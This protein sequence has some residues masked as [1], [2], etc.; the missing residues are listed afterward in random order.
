MIDELLMAGIKGG[1]QGLAQ[2]LGEASAL[3]H[4]NKPMVG[5]LRMQA[6]PR[7]GVWFALAAFCVYR[8]KNLITGE[9]RDIAF[10]EMTL[11]TATQAGG[12][13]IALAAGALCAWAGWRTYRVERRVPS[14]GT[15][16][17]PGYRLP[18]FGEWLLAIVGGL[19]LLAAIY[20]YTTIPESLAAGND[21]RF[22]N[23]HSASAMPV[24]VWGT[25][26]GVGGLLCLIVRRSRWD[27]VP[28][29]PLLRRAITAFSRP[30]PAGSQLALRWEDYWM[31]QGVMRRQVAWV[32]RGMVSTSKGFEIAF[33]PLEATVEQRA[34]I[35]EGW[36]QLISQNGAVQVTSVDPGPPGKHG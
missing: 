31:G 16:W 25:G 2:G 35:G 21:P 22:R 14:P 29:Q 17:F 3:M 12:V 19:F 6:I 7:I 13:A 36:R 10:E 15:L 1:A 30:R 34:A 11:S 20:G 23:Y 8:S 18:L 28:G 26:L 5:H 24:L 27:L 32:L 9:G 33:V 4:G